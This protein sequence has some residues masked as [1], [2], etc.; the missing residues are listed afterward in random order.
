MSERTEVK[1]LFKNEFYQL[2]YVFSVFEG[3]VSVCV[4]VCVGG[5]GGGYKGPV[6]HLLKSLVAD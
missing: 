2:H 1:T 6:L 4:C 5:G 3:C